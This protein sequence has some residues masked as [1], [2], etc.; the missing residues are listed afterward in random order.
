MAAA[1]GYVFSDQQ[2]LIGV[3]RGFEWGNSLIES[4]QSVAA[5]SMDNDESVMSQLELIERTCPNC[6]SSMDS[7]SCKLKC[8]KCGYFKSCSDF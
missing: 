6:D 3:I 8:P 5:N 2:V 1:V 7:H 4:V